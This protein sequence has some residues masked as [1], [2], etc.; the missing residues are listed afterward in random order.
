MEFTCCKVLVLLRKQ[1]KSK[2]KSKLGWLS[3]YTGYRCIL[4]L[5]GSPLKSSCKM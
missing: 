2:L 4:K 3:L 1:E 5:V